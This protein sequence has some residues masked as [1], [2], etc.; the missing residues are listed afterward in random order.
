MLRGTPRH[1]KPEFHGTGFLQPTLSSAG[2]EALRKPLSSV[3]QLTDAKAKSTLRS[4]RLGLRTD[5]YAYATAHPWIVS[6]ECR[7]NEHV[8]KTS[9]SLVAII[10]FDYQS[11]PATKNGRTKHL[12]IELCVSCRGA[13]PLS[14]GCRAPSL[15][16]VP[17]QRSSAATFGKKMRTHIRAA[18]FPTMS[19]QML[20]KL[21]RHSL[22][23]QGRG[24][25]VFEGTVLPQVLNLSD[26]HISK[27]AKR[28]VPPKQSTYPSLPDVGV[29]A[30]AGKPRETNR[31]AR[32]A[33]CSTAEFGMVDRRGL[34]E[35]PVP[36]L[37]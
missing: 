16:C 19:S 30:C 27:C 22:A 24:S 12:R 28:Y 21:S 32:P 31:F 37:G 34:V 2:P 10:C 26:L 36:F 13:L 4:V 8:V 25:W 33:L 17:V 20:R 6:C 35:A 9:A 11:L 5:T 23:P 3:E 7:A 18:L 1:P 29:P 14:R 15:R